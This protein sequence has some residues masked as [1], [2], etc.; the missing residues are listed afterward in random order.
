[1]VA[2]VGVDLEAQVVQKGEDLD[3]SLH[4]GRQGRLEEGEVVDK[5]QQARSGPAAAA[6][7]P[8][9]SGLSEDLVGRALGGSPRGCLRVSEVFDERVGERVEDLGAEGPALG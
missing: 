4:A 7:E 5:G 6:T 2:L 9:A 1:M 3:L 8:A